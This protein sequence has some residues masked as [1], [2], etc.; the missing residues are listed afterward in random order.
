MRT[1]SL[2]DIERGV[3]HHSPPRKVLGL[4]FCGGNNVVAAN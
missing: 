2:A 4:V 1:A 3:S